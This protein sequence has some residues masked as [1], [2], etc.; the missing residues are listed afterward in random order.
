ME[1][2]E[3]LLPPIFISISLFKAYKIVFTFEVAQCAILHIF[4]Q[5]TLFCILIWGSLHYALGTK[6]K[7]RSPTIHI[8]IVRLIEVLITKRFVESLRLR[9]NIGSLEK[10]MPLI[11]LTC[12]KCFHSFIRMVMYEDLFEKKCSTQLCWYET[13]ENLILEHESQNNSK[14]MTN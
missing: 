13:S 6:L 7:M 12:K 3:Q 1:N 5:R 4:R 11:E 8:H 14:Y 9:E 10:F 2:L